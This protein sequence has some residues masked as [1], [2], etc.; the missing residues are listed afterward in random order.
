M[1]CNTQT[2][3]GMAWAL[4]AIRSTAGQREWVLTWH[5]NLVKTRQCIVLF[6]AM[7]RDG[8][9]L[10]GGEDSPLPTTPF[11]SGSPIN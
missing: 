10:L 7:R 8:R 4:T 6:R 11:P 1:S 5:R 9:M 2:V 3:F